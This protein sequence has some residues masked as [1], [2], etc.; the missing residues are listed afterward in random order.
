MT[1]AV[2]VTLELHNEP[3][4]LAAP[5]RIAGHVFESM[6]ATVVTL[7]DGVHAGRGEAALNHVL[8]RDARVVGAGL[9]ERL[10]PLHSPPA[11][12]YVLDRVVQAVSHVQ[13]GRD[14]GRGDD[15]GVRLPIGVGAG[16]EEALLLPP[17]VERS[18]GFGRRVLCRERRFHACQRCRNRAAEPRENRRN[19]AQTAG[20]GRPNDRTGAG[21]GQPDERPL[22]ASAHRRARPQA[23][24]AAGAPLRTAGSP[25]QRW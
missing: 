3:L 16:A 11:D 9:P 18:L 24:A 17:G 19:P 14:V 15:D 21:D 5:F 10:A 8:R 20:R 2:P 6:P 1:A 7:H 13:D 12:D 4:P 25:S 23:T 22:S